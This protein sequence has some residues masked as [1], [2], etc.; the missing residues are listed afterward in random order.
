MFGFRAK[1][2]NGTIQ[3]S[4]ERPYMS[5]HAEGFLN[6]GTAYQTTITFAQPCTTTQPPM[7]FIRP[8]W[9]SQGE[10]L[11]FKC[12]VIGSPGN[13]TG[14]KLVNSN[15]TQISQLDWFA[16]VW[17]PLTVSGNYGMRIRDANG[18]ICF[19]SSSQLI[20]FSRF[21]TYWTHKT[22]TTFYSEFVSNVTLA[23]DE[24]VLVSQCH[25][26]SV[27][28]VMSANR[29]IGVSLSPAGLVGLTTNPAT[30]TNGIG[31]FPMLLAKK[32]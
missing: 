25:S 14:F 15:T 28:A 13:W 17:A 27:A 6:V 20:K 21:I 8:V 22:S 9:A 23:S 5:L 16:A 10:D 4:A 3:L 26:F 1:N 12:G 29:H 7:I 24:Y 11:G 31:Y 19:H 18:N 30:S 2:D 32:S